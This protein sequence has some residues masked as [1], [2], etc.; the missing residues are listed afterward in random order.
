MWEIVFLLWQIWLYIF[1]FICTSFCTYWKSHRRK[2]AN[3]SPDCCQ[4]YLLWHREWVILEQSFSNPIP[5]L[6]FYL[7]FLMM[8]VCQ[9]E[10]AS[11]VSA[12]NSWESVK[13]PIFWVQRWTHNFFAEH[14]LMGCNIQTNDQWEQLKIK[15]ISIT[16]WMYI[17]VNKS[18]WHMSFWGGG[19]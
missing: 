16:E 2:K 8:Q 13:A 10:E 15:C 19:S 17:Q 12:S 18:Q 14:I 3:Y 4:M 6:H 9:W 5:T 7:C 11:P 1:L